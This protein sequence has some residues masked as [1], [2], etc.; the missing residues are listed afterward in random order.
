MKQIKSRV[1]DADVPSRFCP[2]A[3]D[4]DILKQHLIESK[5][6]DN[7]RKREHKKKDMHNK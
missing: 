7:A 4:H 2:L 6:R 3:D 1:N 5:E